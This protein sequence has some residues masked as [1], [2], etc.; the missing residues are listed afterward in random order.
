MYTAPAWPPK[1]FQT[2][3]LELC[4]QKPEKEPSHCLLKEIVNH[5]GDLH[6]IPVDII[7]APG[8][9]A[10]NTQR[11]LQRIQAMAGRGRQQNQNQNLQ[12]ADPA[13]VQILQ[14]MQNRDAN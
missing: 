13:L 1:R 10:A 5:N 12:G 11:G 8:G 14:L 9:R 4:E 2:S 6:I 7:V 3:T